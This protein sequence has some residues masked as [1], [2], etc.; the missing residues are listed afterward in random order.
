MDELRSPDALKHE[1][2][3]AEALEHAV[4]AE[5]LGCMSS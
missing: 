5:Y 3:I 2:G 1:R 4:I